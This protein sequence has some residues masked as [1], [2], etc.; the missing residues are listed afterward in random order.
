MEP[1]IFELPTFDQAY[2]RQLATTLGAYLLGSIPF[3]YLLSK[4]AGY[5]DI[6]EL[7]SGNIGAT[8][9]LRTGNKALAL[10]TLLL[11]FGKG[12]AAV[13]FAIHYY[14]DLAVVAG[15]SALLGHMFPLWLQG[16]GGKGV[17]TSLGIVTALSWQIGISA[18]AV[19]L[20]I[21]ILFRYSSF[22]SLIAIF[23]IPL[24][25]ILFRRPDVLWLSFVIIVLVYTKHGENIKRLLEGTEA[26]IGS[27]KKKAD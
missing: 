25:A 11:D 23:F 15:L 13:M 6:R 8:N 17:A 19:W 1:Q 24:E 18:I 7:G 26:K 9:V 22:A 16:K 5:G 4:M 14:P 12:A 10:L 3:G 2:M 20:I 27:K 21:A